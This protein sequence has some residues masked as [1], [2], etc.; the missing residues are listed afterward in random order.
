MGYYQIN[1]INIS[2]ILDLTTEDTGN[3]CSYLEYS[4][5]LLFSINISQY[6]LRSIV[7]LCSPEQIRRNYDNQQ[8]INKINEGHAQLYEDETKNN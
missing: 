5:R 8:N 4:G 1:I 2:I 3:K 7:K 6:M